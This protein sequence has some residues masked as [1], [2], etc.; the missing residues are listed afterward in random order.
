[1]R[2]IFF[3]FLYYSYNAIAYLSLII[4]EIPG[5]GKF[6]NRPLQ[7][8]DEMKVMFGSSINEEIDHWNPMSSNPIIPPNGDAPL[9]LTWIMVKSM[10]WV[11]M[12]TSTMVMRF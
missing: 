3:L 7:N 1:M 2:L 4:Y 5:V 9:L 6:K 8:E 11:L 12:W 10:I